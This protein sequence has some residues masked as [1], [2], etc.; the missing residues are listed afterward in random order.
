[1]DVESGVRRA[2]DGDLEAF[3]E[4]TR[5]FQHM[6]FGYAFALVRDI[7]RAEDVVQEAFVAAWF[8]LPTL[9]DPAAF[10]GWFRGIVRHQ[11]HRVLRQKSLEGLPLSAAETL[12]ADETAPDRR[13]ELQQRMAGV[14]A[15]ISQLAAPLRQVVTLCYVHECSQRDIATFLG[16]PVTT[17]NNRLHAARQQ[18][19]RRTI[20]MVKDTLGANHLP[21]DFAARIGHIVRARESLIEARFAPDSLPDV[22]TELTVSDERRQRAVTV[23]VIQRLAGGVVRCV[24]LSPADGLLPGASV[25]SSGRRTERLA[26]RDVLDRTVHVLAPGPGA[27]RPLEVLETGIKVIDVTCPLVRG[28][29]VAIAGEYAA[30]TC[31]LVEEL[32]RR[33]ASRP[34]GVSLFTFVPPSPGPSFKE[35]WRREGY[36]EGTLGA[37][38]TFWFLG[39]EAWTAER[40]SVLPGVD[41]VIRL[42][43]GL[44]QQ[45]IYPPI[46]P[47]LSRSRALDAGA[48][49]ERHLGIAPRV[50]RALALLRE[51]VAG[52]AVAMARARKLQRFFG[53]PFFV[54]EPYTKR[55]GV[56]VSMASAIRACE[57][58]LDGAHDDLPEESFSFTG[59]IEEIR[60]QATRP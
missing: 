57:E 43:H 30:G 25:L 21:D 31:V 15:A 49:D 32:V 40:L 8:A 22:L 53:Q 6:A 41:V 24:A 33:L 51:G 28:G 29:T 59:G 26:S 9:V 42:S 12:A 7:R 38:Q 56:S 36:S 54:A 52:D 34:E 45:H 14:L 58:I 44:A 16:I 19:K 60:A 46:D 18:L 23:Q 5:Q 55:P 17:V 37:V 3:A 35:M 11:A 47:V 39:E 48:M 10:P 27:V 50:V 13:L 2:R 4:V 1:M 20:T